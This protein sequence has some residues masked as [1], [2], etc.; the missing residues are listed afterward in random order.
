[1]YVKNLLNAGTYFIPVPVG[2][3]LTVQYGASGRL[4]KVYY[5]HVLE[6]AVDLSKELLS[7]FISTDIVPTE[8][9][10]KNGTTWIRGI[11]YTETV[12]PIDGV[13]PADI[14]EIGRAHV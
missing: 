6:K 12:Y 3:P 1:M 9:P 8:I 13:L 2:L 10:M 5:G 14:K 11:L 4:Q 7:N